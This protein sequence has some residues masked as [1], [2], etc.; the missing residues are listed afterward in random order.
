MFCS[1]VCWSGSVK[2]MA[3]V[4]SLTGFLASAHHDLNNLRVLSDL[5]RSSSHVFHLPSSFHNSIWGVPFGEYASLKRT[6]QCSWKDKY[7]NPSKCINFKVVESF[8]D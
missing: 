8:N 2:D 7:C 1:D 4:T 3:S 6:L 5:S